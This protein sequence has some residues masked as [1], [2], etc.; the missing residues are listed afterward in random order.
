MDG[1]G[2]G[3]RA[4]VALGGNAII[5]EGEEGRIDQQFRNTRISLSGVVRLIKEGWEVL[6]THGNGPQV[7][8]R[9]LSNEM[10]HE[11]VPNLPLGVLC[12][13]TEGA[14]GY[15]IQQSLV[16][17]LIYHSIKSS[18]V[19]V[20]TQTEVDI[21]DMSMRNPTKPIGPFYSKEESEKLE[22]EE[23]WRF[24]EDSGRGYRQVVPSPYPIDI[25][26]IDVIKSLLGMGVIVI[27][28]GGGGI[29]VMRQPD[30]TLE[31][32]DG[33][34]DKDLASSLAGRKI[35]ASLFVMV[36]GVEKVALNYGKPN[37]KNIDKMTVSE[38]VG[39]LDGGHFPPGSMG[40]K[41]RAAVEFLEGGEGGEGSGVIITSP[42]GLSGAV[43]GG[44]GTTIV[45]D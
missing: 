35:G 26:E 44:A 31:G 21:D 22:R 12:G 41:I 32:V 14:M 5:R 23:G 8:N 42:E 17:K 40:P 4:V 11:M 25:I 15:M 36:T 24:V 9:L 43:F 10:A 28:L 29:P 3:K 45:K 20:I 30:G 39:Y 38:A 19:T 18:V 16:N 33:I 13:D 37:Q 34:I 27:A 6:I 2:G 7:G 1:T